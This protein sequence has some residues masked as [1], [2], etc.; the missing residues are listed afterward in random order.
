[1]PKAKW[2]GKFVGLI[3]WMLFYLENLEGFAGQKIQFRSYKVMK[4]LK[5]NPI[6][7]F[8]KIKFLKMLKKFECLDVR[9]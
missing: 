7:I 4:I 1:M 9:Q 8:E 5:Q 2:C 6:E 3:M